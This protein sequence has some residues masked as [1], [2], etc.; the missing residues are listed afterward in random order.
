MTA[1]ARFAVPALA[2]A[3]MLVGCVPE[4]AATPTETAP[5]PASSAP[6]ATS[7]SA[8][9]SVTATS[10]T[11]SAAP[12]ATPG[13]FA[14][15]AD[16]ESVYSTAMLATLNQ[17]I[18]PLNDPGV[19]LFSSRNARALELLDSGIPTLRCSWG[20]PSEA[21]LAT[22]VSILD[23]EQSQALQ[24]ALAQA[25]FGCEAAFGG[26]QCRIEQQSVD[27]DDQLN[28]T[29]EIHYFSGDGWVSTA[30]VNVLP[31]GYTQDIANTL[32]G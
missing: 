27:L 13:A 1:S 23:A 30:Y 4:P 26:T 2:L 28:T 16:C 9:P 20:T 7:A 6:A 29:G 5:P 11:P 10:A 21:G 15:P 14:M 17:Q 8:T 32:W 25:G 24:D 22:N 19:T 31:D 3:L 12:S 18:A